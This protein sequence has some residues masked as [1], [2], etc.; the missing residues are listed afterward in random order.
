MNLECIIAFVPK[1]LISI[2]NYYSV[3]RLELVAIKR[4][5]LDIR[6]DR[7][8]RLPALYSGHRSWCRLASVSLRLLAPLGLVERSVSLSVLAIRNRTFEALASIAHGRT[9]AG[10]RPGAI[11]NRYLSCGGASVE[12]LS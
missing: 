1:L 4:A 7:H 9:V 12:T 5:R 2:I 8:C 6:P 11:T 3:R 10:Q